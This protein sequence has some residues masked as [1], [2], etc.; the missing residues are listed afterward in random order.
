MGEQMCALSVKS[1]HAQ[2]SLVPRASVRYT[3]VEDCWGSGNETMLKHTTERNKL[4][5][6]HRYSNKTL[7][8]VVRQGR[9]PVVMDSLPLLQG[10]WPINIAL[11]PPILENRKS[12]AIHWLRTCLHVTTQ[13]T[14]LPAHTEVYIA[15]CLL[16]TFT[17]QPTSHT[18]T[19]V[20]WAA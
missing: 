11:N 20:L 17:H 7:Y 14:S 9:H 12:H 2:T 18:V 5:Q 15:Q 19:M 6:W 13:A 4:K 8:L 10:V 3:H 16:P 1:M